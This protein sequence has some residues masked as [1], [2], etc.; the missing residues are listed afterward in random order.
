VTLRPEPIFA[1]TIPRK[2]QAYLASGVPLLGMLDGEES[3]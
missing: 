2:L 1:L 3:A